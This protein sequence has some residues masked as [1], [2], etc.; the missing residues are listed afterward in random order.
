MRLKP[1]LGGEPFSIIGHG[2]REEVI[3]D[4]RVANAGARAD[5]PTGLEM[6]C[7]SMPVA[8]QQPA[9]T[10][11]AFRHQAL[12]GVERDRLRTGN[13]KIEFQVVLQVFTDAGQMM[14][15]LDAE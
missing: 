8:T 3:L 14:R 4:V 2:E 11:G 12:P 9:G 7:G 15:Y 5:E 1:M 13:L 10:D 6:V